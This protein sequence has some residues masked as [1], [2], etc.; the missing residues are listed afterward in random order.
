[1]NRECFLMKGCALHGS[2]HGEEPSLRVSRKVATQ[3]TGGVRQPLWMPIATGSPKHDRRAHH[4]AGNRDN[5]RVNREFLI[6]APYANTDSSFPVRRR[7]NAYTRRTGQH[8]D[9]ARSDGWSQGPD[10]RINFCIAGTK[11]PVAVPAED[12][13][14]TSRGS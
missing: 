8:F 4:A 13:G 9:E 7:Q 5:P 1:V 3:S 6:P 10:F 14:A 12:A 11:V 2:L